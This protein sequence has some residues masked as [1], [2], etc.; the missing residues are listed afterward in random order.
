MTYAVERSIDEGGHFLSGRG[1]LHRN[2]TPVILGCIAE[3][4]GGGGG[5]GGGGLAGRLDPLEALLPSTVGRARFRSPFT[6]S[7]MDDVLVHV[8]QAT[9]L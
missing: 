7:D 6:V 3:K 5:A 2:S 9:Q 8:S 4:P 1:S